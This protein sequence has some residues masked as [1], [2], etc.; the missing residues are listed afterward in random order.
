MVAELVTEQP[1][2]AP[3]A[4]GTSR[5]QVGSRVSLALRLLSIGPLLILVILVV[6]ISLLTP[7]FLKPIN[8]SNILAQTAVIAIVAMGQQ[9]VILTRGID[10][11]VGA[12]LALATVIGGLAFRAGRLRA[13][14]HAGDA[15]HRRRRRRGQRRRLRFR[16]SAPSL[17]HHARHAQHLP[18]PR[19]RTVDRPHDHA[20]HARDNRDDRQRRHVRHP[21]FILRRARWSRSP[22]WS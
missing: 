20:R 18:G 6:A 1:E 14:R 19:A 10:L 2:A 15:C 16:P 8:I 9:L 13:A 3:A 17:H 5:P 7:N 4:P 22:F 21:Q 11:S 12:N